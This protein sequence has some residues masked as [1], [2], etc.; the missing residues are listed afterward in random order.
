[1]SE[2]RLPIHIRLIIY[3]IS[4]CAYLLVFHGS[5]DSRTQRAA[6][7]LKQLSIEKW[8]SKDILAQHNYLERNLSNFDLK[9]VTASNLRATPMI[10]IAALELSSKSLNESLAE[11][12][13]TAH[14][15][16]IEQVKVLPLFLAPG[17][18][19]VED[20]PAEIALA[21]KQL[22][23]YISIKLCPY[24]GKYSAIVPLLSR[25]FAQL[26]AKSRIIV[27]HGSKLPAV[28]DYYQNLASKLEADIAYWSTMP[29]FTQ[30]IK[31][32]IASGVKKIAIL[33]Y[34][35]FPGRITAAIAQ[36]IAIL[37]QEY[38]Q[39]ELILGQPLGATSVAELIL[40]EA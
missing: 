28:S 9:S 7:Q 8:Q 15:Q 2:F 5:R 31:Q 6:N 17:V 16:G 37:R 30:R 12:A 1:M 24:L 26:P 33:P 32:Q 13:R 4:S 18:H 40:Q 29:K 21:I 35:L 27:A 38:P 36:E 10:E 23:F 20:I 11:F 34:F 14:Q 19:V 39:V 3:L 22:D 25:K